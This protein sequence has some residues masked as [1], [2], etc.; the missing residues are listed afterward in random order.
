[1]TVVAYIVGVLV[2]AFGVAASIA[3]HEIGHLVPAKK[4]GLRVT[5]YMVGFG[6]TIWSRRRGETEYGIKAI[7][8]GGYIRMIGMFPPR[9]GQDPSMVR[10]SSTGR[11]SQLADEARKASLEELRPGDENRVFYRLPVHRK[12]IIMLGGPFMNFVIGAVLLAI[13]VTAHG[14]LALQDGARVAAV[15]ECVKTVEEAKADPSCTGAPQ[16]PANAAGLL[17]G[18]EFVSINGEPVKTSA[19]VGR[20]IRPRVDQ[21]TEVVVL[22]GGAE[23][24]LSVTPI[25]NTLPAYDDQGQPILEANGEQ[26]VVETGYLGVSSAAILDY[27]TQPVTAVPGIIGENLWRTAGAVVR[28]PQKMVGVWN[29]AFSG[30]ERDVESPMSVVGVGRVAGEVS[31]GQLDNLVGESWSDKAWFLVMLIASLNFM[32]FI[33]N[34]IPLLPLDGGHVAG[35]L[36]EGVK[37]GWAKLRGNPD[38]GHVDVA[39]ALPVAYAVSLG[40]LVMSALLIYADLVNPIDLGG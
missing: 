15:A 17:P 9:K 23:Q 29:A 21:P 34:L 38:P 20:L 2:L 16:T 6:P 37:K 7:P 11:F 30:E 27:E 22:R 40:L 8:L 12:I 1:M 5:Q 14:V 39:K 35:A 13:L 26:K 3:L 32:L 33:F 24:S 10:V 28:I 4:F 19:D 31:A 36:W 18:D 25:L